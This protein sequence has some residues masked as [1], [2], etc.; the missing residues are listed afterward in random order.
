MKPIRTDKIYQIIMDEISDLIDKTQLI[1]GDRLPSERTIATRLSV[2]RSSVR[3]ATSVLVA[4]GV[5]VVKQG[6]GTYVADAMINNNRSLLEELSVSLAKQQISPIEIAEA[7]LF[8]ECET[9]RLCAIHINDEICNRLKKIVT[10]YDYYDNRKDSLFKINQNLHLTIAEGSE[11]AVLEIMMKN[12]LGLM[13]GNMWRW[14][15][16][17]GAKN[18]AYSFE[19]HKEQHKAIVEAI[20][21]HDSKKAKQAMY[22]HL[23][24]IGEEMTMLFNDAQARK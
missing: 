21:N 10:M 14:A 20:I 3:Q 13:N 17:Q 7:R 15:K 9:T 5:L 2:S 23:V 4:R 22:D 18:R 1:P 6:D 8:I 11:N 19:L 12:I 16:T 24:N